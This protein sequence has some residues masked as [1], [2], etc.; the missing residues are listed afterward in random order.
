[1]LRSFCGTRLSFQ[2]MVVVGMCCVC[3]TDV[4]STDPKAS[5]LRSEQGQI[6]ARNSTCAAGYL[7]GEEKVEWGMRDGRIDLTVILK[8][9]RSR[10]SLA[11]PSNNT[12]N[13]H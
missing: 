6:S 12:C 9:R 5:S 7:A 11:G 1:M 10:C 4:H 8:T 2:T 13:R 3:I